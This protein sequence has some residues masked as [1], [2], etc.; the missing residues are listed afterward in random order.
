MKGRKALALVCYTVCIAA[1]I[2]AG[3]VS[4]M[5]YKQ[6]ITYTFGFLLFVPIWIGS[7]WFLTFFNDLSRRKVGKK[8]KFVLKK[9]LTRGLSVTANVLSVL[10][11]C[12]WVYTYIF[13]IMPGNGSTDKNSDPLANTSAVTAEDIGTEDTC[14][15]LGAETA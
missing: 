12:F 14:L 15:T 6:K 7:F 4:F 1:C 11:L 13:K 2:A 3:V 5:A 8:T 9:S 10:L